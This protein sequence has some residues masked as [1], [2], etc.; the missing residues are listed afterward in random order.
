MIEVHEVRLHLTDGQSVE[1]YLEKIPPGY[2]GELFFPPMSN[3]LLKVL[4]R[5]PQQF[6]TANECYEWLVSQALRY[7]TEFNL[8]GVDKFEPVSGGGEMDHSEEAIGKLVV[9]GGDGAVDLEV[10]EHAL[11]AV[12]LLV[13]RP[14][15]PDFHAAV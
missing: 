9:A 6:A 2:M 5:S 3:N 13:E 15:M 1:C 10:S 14:I 7:A 4:F 8:G 12:A 11:D